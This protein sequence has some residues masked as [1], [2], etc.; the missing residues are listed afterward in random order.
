L[1]QVLL[2]IRLYRYRARVAYDGTN[3]QGF[4]VQ[5]GSTRRTVQGELE[6]VLSQRLNEPIRVVGAGR[7]DSGVH[8][9]G[10]AVHFD[11]TQNLSVVHLENVQYSIEKMIPKDIAFWNLQRVPPPVTKTINGKVVAKEWNV[12]YDSTHKLYSYRLNVHSTMD[13]IE[14]YHRWHPDRVERWFSIEDFTR[15]LQYYV[16]THDFRAFTSG[17]DALERRLGGQINTTR[18]VYSVDVIQEDNK[19]NI[20]V[21]IVL[22]GALYKQVRNLI[23]TALLV[24]ADKL[25]KDLFRRLIDNP[26]GQY[27]RED[28]PAKPAPPEGLTLERVY[29]IDDEI[30]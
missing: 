1:I 5:Q 3:F 11:C 27:T 23:G 20:R 17:M 19:G 9:R 2:A 22:K 14:R 8:S 15:L 29:F 25:D 13:P 18:T 16:G 21:D 24:C 4:Q 26:T 6:K 7:T 28:N 30:F 10:Q 12:M